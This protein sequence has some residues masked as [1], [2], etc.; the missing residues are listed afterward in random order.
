M[1]RAVAVAASAAMLAACTGLPTSGSPEA[2][3]PLGG[4]L[5]APDITQLASGPVSGASPEEVVEG[6]LEAGITPADGWDIAR[7]FL[8]PDLAESWSPSV[9]TTIDAGTSSRIITSMYEGAEEEASTA[10]VRV[11]L[12]QVAS[13]DGTGAYSA[14]SGQAEMPSF[15]LQRGAG[16]EWRIAE[17]PDGIV[18]D[19][20]SF[21]QVFRAHALKYFDPG[22]ERLVPDVR[23]FPRRA[24]IVTSITQALIEGEPTA[25]LAPGVRDAFPA[26]VIARGAVPVTA[27]V[28]EVALNRAALGLD[29]QTLARM[30]TQLER[31]LS[32][33][34]VSSVRFTVDGL[35]LEAGTV[36]LKEGPAETGSL[37]LTAEHFGTLVGDEIAPVPG[38]TD[39]I[40]GIVDPITAIDVAADSSSAAVQLANGQILSVG[41]DQVDRLDSPIDAIEPSLDPQGFIWSAPVSAPGELVAW[42]SDT[43]EHQIANAWPEAAT[44]SYLRVAADG[45]RVAALVT[46]GGQRWVVVAVVLRDEAGVPTELGPMK[47]LAALSGDGAGLVWLGDDALGVLVDRDD[48]RLLTQLV[49]GPGTSVEAPA[50]AVSIAGATNLSGVR[51]LDEG[52]EVLARRGSAWQ[53][54]A[55][56]VLVLA[57]RAGR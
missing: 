3:L 41:D 17:A 13:V 36:P 11:R 53:T 19:A 1:L 24:T 35:N 14:A 37:V 5:D 45:A 55:S 49:G 39:E 34:G 46:V 50:D 51:M 48:P 29:A 10:E 47:Q 44:I 15:Q 7:Q 38:I 9:G 8:T 22:W 26:D 27:Q 23:W 32:G 40:V 21:P 12:E 30:R 4:S 42:S 18:L 56:G 2:G 43:A 31:S 20:V 54:A 6:F 25:W 16:G 57:T 28:A 52:G 33:A